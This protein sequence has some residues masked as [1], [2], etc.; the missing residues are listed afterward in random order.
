MKPKII[1][2]ISVFITL[3]ICLNKQIVLAQQKQHLNDVSIN[4]V[5]ENV[6]SGGACPAKGVIDSNRKISPLINSTILLQKVDNNNDTLKITT[7]NLGIATAQLEA[8]SYYYFMTEM[9]DKSLGCRFNPTSDANL[10]Q[11]FGLLTIKEGRTEIYTISFKFGSNSYQPTQP[12]KNV[13]NNVTLSVF[14]TST[15]CSG[16]WPPQE[17]LDSYRKERPL[18]NSTILL[19]NV[20]D[21]S[22]KIKVTTDETGNAVAQINTGTYNIYMTESYTG[23]SFNSSC[24]IW[25]KQCFGQLSIIEGENDG[26]KIVYNFGCDP[27]SPPQP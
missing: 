2:F 8:G 7:N 23:C 4:V 19:Q 21:K 24:D 14:F 18:I 1:F 11:C 10:K 6:Y 15:Y 9:F 27:C 26:Y 12:Y 13:K 20:S 5:F 17:V 22:K 16:A 25:L 3:L